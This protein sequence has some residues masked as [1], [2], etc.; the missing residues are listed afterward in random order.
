[1]GDSV[2]RS[3]A[4]AKVNLALRVTGRR[5]EGAPF[6]G[7]HE[8][9]SLV[10]FAGVGDRVSAAPADNLSLTLSGRFASELEA[11]S[12]NLV[13]RAARSLA[14]RMGSQPRAALHLEKNLPVASGI[15]GGSADAAAALRCLVSL[16]DLRLPE[17]AL[18]DLAAK[19]G[20]DVPVCLASQACRMRGIGE[21]LE[22]LPPLPAF[23][24]LLANPGRGVSTPAVF[25]A[26][27]AGFSPALAIPSGGFRDLPA[28]AAFLEESGNDLLEPAVHLV[29]D[30]APLLDALWGQPGALYAGL[31]GSGATCIALFA[32]ETAARHAEQSLRAARAAPWIAAA[33]AHPAL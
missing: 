29:P 32:E 16:W 15:G 33:A 24:L 23:W 19:L 30:I 14:E 20:A 3:P 17:G 1:M 6:A 13:L 11:D 22:P 27:P 2:A 4:W 7:S 26:R 25:K 28:L 10:V 31:S 12:D 18:I 21:S 5:P 9:D 8:L